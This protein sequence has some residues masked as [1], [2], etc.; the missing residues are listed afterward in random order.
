MPVARLEEAIARAHE[1]LIGMVRARLADQLSANRRL[2]RARLLR[3]LCAAWAGGP[4]AGFLR[5]MEGAAMYFRALVLTRAGR[6][7]RP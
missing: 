7:S 3:N 1:T 2:W 6:R 5:V 4:F